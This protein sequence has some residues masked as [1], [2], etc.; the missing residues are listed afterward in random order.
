MRI[1][2]PAYFNGLTEEAAKV[3][4]ARFLLRLAAL[5]YSPKGNLADLSQ[6]LGYHPATLSGAQNITAEM[7]VSL[8]DLLGRETFPRTLFRPDLFIVEE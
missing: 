6:A 4:T 3:A 1:V 8:E 2:Y 7:A 5:Y